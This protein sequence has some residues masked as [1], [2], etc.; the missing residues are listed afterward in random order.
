M[1]TLESAAPRARLT[2]SP[3]QH[4]AHHNRDGPDDH[5]RIGQTD[6]HASLTA[7]HNRR[8]GDDPDGRVS[9]T[10]RYGAPTT[11]APRP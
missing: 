11:T 8:N 5:P 7:H 9:S 10:A 2:P 1:T 3:L 4:P 6:E